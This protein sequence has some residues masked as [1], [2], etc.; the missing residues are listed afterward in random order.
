M[1]L[2]WG[3]DKYEQNFVSKKLNGRGRFGDLGVDGGWQ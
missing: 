2:E 3:D 1:E